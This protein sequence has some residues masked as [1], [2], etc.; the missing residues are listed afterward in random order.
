MGGDV[1]SDADIRA[2]LESYP[3]RPCLYTTT[4]HSNLAPPCNPHFFL[5]VNKSPKREK[6]ALFFRAPMPMF[7]QKRTKGV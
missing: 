5:H 3:C 2:G 4:Q 6:S 7:I 1:R